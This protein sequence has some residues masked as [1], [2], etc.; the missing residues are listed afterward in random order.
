MKGVLIF[1]GAGLSADSGLP[2]FRTDGGLWEGHRVEDVCTPMAFQKDPQLVWKFYRDRYLS[3]SGAKP[4]A[5]HVAIAQIEQRCEAEGVPFLLATQNVDGLHA[6]AGS[7]K[8]VELHGNIAKFQCFG[9]NFDT[10]DYTT[11]ENL[12]VNESVP[13]C[14]KCRSENLRPSITWFFE[15]L[16][17]AA[18]MEAIGFSKDADVVVSV[19]TSLNVFPAAD[20]VIGPLN[21][22]AQV[23]EVNLKPYLSGCGDVGKNY[24]F[25][26]GRAADVLPEI[27]KHIGAV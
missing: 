9:I 6:A 4:N 13:V 26:K 10:C 23:V 3:Y 24:I 18:L 22:G 27:V 12:W 1:T 7:K 17:P 8:L 15:N 19:G 21:R 2:T 20:L 11:E 25:A 16:S 5:G 14:P